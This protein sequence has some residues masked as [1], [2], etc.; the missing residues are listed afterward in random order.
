MIN[1]NGKEFNK[2]IDKEE[3]EKVIRSLAERINLDYASKSILFLVVLKGSLFV[4]A[5]LL[6][7]IKSDSEIAFISAK[8]YG[9][10]MQSSGNVAITGDYPNI[11]GRHV[12]IIEDIVDT[13]LT[14]H[15]LIKKLLESKPASLE[16]LAF[17]SKTEMRKTDVNVKYIGIEIPPAFVVGYGLDFAEKGR[18][19]PD[20][21]IIKSLLK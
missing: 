15:S 6:R 19:Y 20:I 2:F 7:H 1:I 3:I 12:I 18:C 9:N 16:A 4:A 10:E 14:L 11:E 21:Y 17:L 13:G 5:D 8:S